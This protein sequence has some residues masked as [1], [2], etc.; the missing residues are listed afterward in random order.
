MGEYCLFVI[1]Y[2]SVVGSHTRAGEVDGCGRYSCFVAS[3][4]I[5]FVLFISSARIPLVW[6]F[7]YFLF[8]LRI[9]FLSFSKRVF[10]P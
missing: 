3:L 5:H 8:T 10:G 6:T 7:H 2:A 9:L 4:F 1:L